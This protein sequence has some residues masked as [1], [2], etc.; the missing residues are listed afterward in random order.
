MTIQMDEQAGVMPGATPESEAYFYLSSLAEL[1]IQARLSRAGKI[2]LAPT[3]LV[4]SH[5]IR[6]VDEHR[7]EIK[8]E[9]SRWAQE[10]ERST[11]Q[12]RGTVPAAAPK[13]LTDPRPDPR[14]DLESDSALWVRLLATAETLDPN[15]A[16]ALHGFR[17]CGARLRRSATG[18]HVVYAPESDWPDE[19]A[20]CADR[21]R[22]LQPD[23]T[24]IGLRDSPMTKALAKLL[25]A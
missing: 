6:V 2:N 9:I 8:E 21:V 5:I 15:L 3:E 7:A 12:L 19:A 13:K 10:R 24:Y 4:T 22:W 14:P 20:F 25:G 17:C 11:D 18:W 1:G 23:Q 16:G